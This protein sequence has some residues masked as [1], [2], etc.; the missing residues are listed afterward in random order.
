MSGTATP[1]AEANPAEG[2][3]LEQASATLRSK[4]F[5]VLLVLVSIVGVVVSLAAWCFLEL[6][7]QIQQ[8]VFT[9]LPHAVGYSHGPP[10]WWP[11]P[12]L[13]IAGVIVALAISKLPGNGGHIPAYGLAAG[14]PPAAAELPGLILAGMASIGLGVVIGPESPLIAL[15][16]GLGVIAIRRARSDATDQV[17]TLV[18]AAGSFAALSFVFSSPLA[19]AVIM[20]EVTAIGGPR[21]RLVLV[22]GLLA[23]GIGSLVSLGMGSFTGLSSSAYAISP[24]PLPAFGHPHLGNFGWTIAL[25]IV[26]AALAHM[27]MRGGLGILGIAKPRLLMVLPV[28]GLLIAG[29]AIAFSQAT[30]HSVDEVLFDGQAQ[31][32]GLVANAGTY[33]LGA[34][35]LLVLCKGAAYSLSLGSFRGGPTFPAMYLGAVAGIMASHLAGFPMTAGVAVGIAAG[36]SSILR[37]PLTAVVIATVLTSKAGDGVEPLIIVGSVV[38]IVVTLLLSPRKSAAPEPS[39]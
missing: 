15:G 24:V 11:L 37:L 29:L 17:V 7:Y 28:A 20:I 34:L 19:A 36:V 2:L 30:G 25:A 18:A 35:A 23:A 21:L 31:L 13:A 16:G 4:P 26:V 38:A 33:S 39:A 1:P 27:L 14:G 22:P 3:T 32:P 5:M 10:V 6:V 8:E 9:H 12:V